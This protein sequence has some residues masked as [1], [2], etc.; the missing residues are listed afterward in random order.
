M[1][2]VWK[3]AIASKAYWVNLNRSVRLAHNLSTAPER[4]MLTCIPPLA[5]KEN[6]KKGGIQ[7]EQ[8]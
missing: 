7:H 4:R 5:G 8:V 2:A 1:L 3:L 6:R